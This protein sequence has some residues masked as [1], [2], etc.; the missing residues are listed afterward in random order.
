MSRGSSAGT[1][2]SAA[3]TMVAARASGRRSLSDPLK[4]RPMGERA[5]ATMTASGMGSST[6]RAAPA[7][8]RRRVPPKLPRGQPTGPTPAEALLHGPAPGVRGVG[9]GGSSISARDGDL[10]GFLGLGGGGQLLG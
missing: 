4:A 1:L 7:P 8:E 2:S 3:R 9:A 10:G 5:G 6:N